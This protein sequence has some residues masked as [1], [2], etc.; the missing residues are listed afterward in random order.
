MD[1]QQR[2]GLN[3]YIRRTSLWDVSG[4]SESGTSSGKSQ[5]IYWRGPRSLELRVRQEII[6]LSLCYHH[7]SDPALRR[8]GAVL[9]E[10]IYLSLRCHHLSDFALRQTAAVLTEIIRLSQQQH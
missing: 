8:E 7:L 9:P 2:G 4:D 10:I 3:F 6:H 1:S 5:E